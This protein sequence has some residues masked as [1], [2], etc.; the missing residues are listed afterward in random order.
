MDEQAYKLLQRDTVERL[1][2]F[3]ERAHPARQLARAVNVV[4]VLLS[5]KTLLV[6]RVELY[7]GS[8]ESISMSTNCRLQLEECAIECAIYLVQRGRRRDSLP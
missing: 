1:D 4:R 6:G 7:H 5:E 2:A 8:R 3:V